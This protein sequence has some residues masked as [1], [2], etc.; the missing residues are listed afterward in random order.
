[1]KMQSVRGFTLWELLVSILV[2]G[3]LL[4]IGVPNFLE[5]RRNNAMAAAANDLVSAIMLARAEAVKRQVPVTLCA[6]PDPLAATPTCSP[7]GA[8]SN[9]AFIV[10]VDENGNVDANGAPILTDGSDG[11]AVVDAGELVLLRREDPGSTINVSADSGYIAYGP[12]GFRRNVAGLGPSASLV[13]YCDERGN[14]AA[15]G[16][17]STARVLRVDPTGRGQV[18]RGVPEVA[19]AITAIGAACP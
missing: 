9:G 7:T 15:A 16:D 10:W 11:D 1:M 13:L 12:N 17:V 3:I 18:V 14:R 8:G 6:S 4:G 19:A 5:F 2:V